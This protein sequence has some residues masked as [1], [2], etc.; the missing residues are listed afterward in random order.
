[1][2]GHTPSAAGTGVN[3]TRANALCKPAAAGSSGHDTGRSGDGSSATTSQNT[4]EQRATFVQDGFVLPRAPEQGYVND[5]V[6]ARA[7]AND[8]NAAGSVFDNPAP[9]GGGGGKNKHGTARADKKAGAGA[10]AGAGTGGA[11]KLAGK[12]GHDYVAAAGAQRVGSNQG[13]HSRRPAKKHAYLDI[14]Y[15]NPVYTS[16]TFAGHTATGTGAQ[17]AD[18]AD[19]YAG[20]AASGAGLQ[21]GADTYAGYAASGAGLQSDA[22]TYAGY[23]ASGAGLQAAIASPDYATASLNSDANAPKAVQ[24]SACSSPTYEQRPTTGAPP[25]QIALYANKSSKPKSQCVYCLDFVSSSTRTPHGRHVQTSNRNQTD[26]LPTHESL[27]GSR[28]V[29]TTQPRATARSRSRPRHR[30]PCHARR[31]GAGPSQRWPAAHPQRS[32]RRRATAAPR[33]LLPLPRACDL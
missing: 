4:G 12:S 5:D 9:E 23:A 24:T 2:E 17:N 18:S 6:V 29:G 15:G 16:N 10:G 27:N 1:M 33:R 26:C 14:H 21:S 13:T 25:R 32:T 20:Y 8:P 22:D 3:C 7:L 28:H 19:T 31:G 30:G 11:Q